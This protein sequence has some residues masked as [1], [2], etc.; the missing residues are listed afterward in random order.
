MGSVWD[1]VPV[2]SLVGR[3]GSH[4]IA[5]TGR[6]LMFESVSVSFLVLTSQT[7]TKPPEEPV[8]RI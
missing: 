6:R 3:S 4:A 1:G 7:V 2:I 8:T 5:L